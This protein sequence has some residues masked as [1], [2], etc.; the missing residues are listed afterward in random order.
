MTGLAQR[1]AFVE[2]IDRLKG[3]LRRTRLINEERKEN[4]AE[5]SWHVA[6]MALAL[7]PDAPQ[8]VNIDRAVQMLLVHDIVEI[9]VGDTFAYDEAGH[10]EKP[11]KE[12]RAARRIFGLLPRSEGEHYIDLWK[13]Y[14]AAETPDGAFAHSVDRF[15]PILHNYRTDGHAWR[16]HGIRRSQ[17][18]KRNAVIERGC[19]SLWPL[20]LQIVDDAVAHGMLID[21]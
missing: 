18:L 3:V 15:L 10:R 20:V 12:A 2:E 14:E 16:E 19:P 4:T 9:D 6:M 1:I 13:E 17:V 7:A 5:H 21:G 8:G 11:A